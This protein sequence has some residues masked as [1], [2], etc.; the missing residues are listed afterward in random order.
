MAIAVSTGLMSWQIRLK[1]T[2]AV[3]FPGNYLVSY[4]TRVSNLSEVYKLE[5][6]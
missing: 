4:A 6:K 3:V 5:R 1:L 2:Q